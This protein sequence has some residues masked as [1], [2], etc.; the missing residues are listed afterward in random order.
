MNALITDGKNTGKKI[1]LTESA[2]Q[3]KFVESLNLDEIMNKDEK[4]GAY[5][6]TEA[7]ATWLKGMLRESLS[8][9][10]SDNVLAFIKQAIAALSQNK[11]YPA[12]ITLAKSALKDAVKIIEKERLSR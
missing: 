9:S 8:D 12:D 7:D 3:E 6:M 4:S 10:Q 11:T 1:R 2:K 5:R